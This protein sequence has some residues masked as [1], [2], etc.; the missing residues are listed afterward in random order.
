[1]LLFKQKTAYEKRMSDWSSDVCSSD[2]VE[3][4]HVHV[5]GLGT[6]DAAPV[7]ACQPAGQVVEQRG[8]LGGDAGAHEH[9]VDAR[10]HARKSV[11]SGKSVS[12][13]VDLVVR[14]TI[15]K[16]RYHKID[17]LSVV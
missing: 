1:M 16:T 13:R 5:A 14:R 12:V 11:V 10:E 3:V 4:D 9:V 2:L 7:V 15:T 8:D 6:R 17:K